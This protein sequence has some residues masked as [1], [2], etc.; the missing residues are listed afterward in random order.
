MLEVAGF[1]QA[2]NQAKTIEA[3]GKLNALQEDVRITAEEADRKTLLA[4]AL[5]SQAASAAGRGISAFEGS[6]LTVMAETSR[7]SQVEGERNRF[8]SEVAKQA[9][10]YR[11]RT[12]SNQIKSQSL[13]QLGK[14]LESRASGFP[15]KGTTKEKVGAVLF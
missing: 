2:R 7:R 1:M 10:L 8:S 6:P 9:G 15:T 4:D 3:E 11:A 14:D 13:L 5:A 12:A